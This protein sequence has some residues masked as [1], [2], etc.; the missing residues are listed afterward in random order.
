MILFR[1][2]VIALNWFDIGIR[3]WTFIHLRTNLTHIQRLTYT[4]LFSWLPHLKTTHLFHLK[5]SS[6]HFILNVFNYI[7]FSY[8][9]SVIYTKFVFSFFIVFFF[10][11]VTFCHLLSLFFQ[12]YRLFF[13]INWINIWCE[14]MVLWYLKNVLILIAC[15]SKTKFI[16]LF[17][18]ILGSAILFWVFFLS[19]F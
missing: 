11:H 2:S 4:Q 8:T 1:T 12:K 9:H 17:L 13:S 14:K 15:K 6:L 18:R 3:L 7:A 10:I 19:S 5:Q 16:R